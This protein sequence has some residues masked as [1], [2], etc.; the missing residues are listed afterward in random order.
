NGV[1]CI[2]GT[3]ERAVLR[4][5]HGGTG[6]ELWTLDKAFDG[7]IGFAGG[8][9]V[10]LG[11]VTRDGRLDIVALTGESHV[12][13]IQGDGTV[14]DV[15]DV[16]FAD[17]YPQ[18]TAWGGALAL[19][20]MDR[21]GW[22]EVAYSSAVWTTKD[23]TV[24]RLFKN[25]D[26]SFGGMSLSSSLSF[27]ADVTGDAD[28]E[29][30]VG[31]RVINKAGSTVWTSA[32]TGDGFAAVA[33]LDK[34][35]SPEV[36]VVADG[37][38]TVIQGSDGAQ[39]MPPYSL[40]GTGHGGSPTIAD[41]DGDTFPEIGIAQ[42]QVYLMLKPNL[43]TMELEGV[44]SAP[45]HDLSSS[46]TGSTVFDF[47]G[48]GSAEVV[49]NDEC[50]VWVY[51]GKT[52]AVKWATPTKSFT[53]TESSI[54]ADVDGD[55]HAEILVI[56]NGVRNEDPGGGGIEWDCTD[57]GY[58]IADPVTGRPAWEPDSMGRMWTGLRLFRD[59][60]NSWVNTR[61]LWNQHAYSVSNVCDPSDSA[62]APTG[63]Y[64]EI[65]TN[66]QKN[67]TLPWLNNFRQNVQDQGVFNAADALVSLSVTC[68][69]LPVLTVAV[70]NGG[71][72]ILPAGI[73]V[74]VFRVVDGKEELVAEAT[75][76]RVIYPGGS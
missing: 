8:V 46:V 56:G 38:V 60:A 61:A 15:S 52:G 34:N 22:S 57:D 54:V 16:P 51:D 14:E 66:A 7:S 23:K 53:A 20:D 63:L 67:W 37:K 32:A 62:C 26:G 17:P 18:G 28:P 35:G 76:E 6:E 29:L 33:D 11:D 36:V 43:T 40:G 1:F 44:W 13:I 74:S 25:E 39:W 3:C 4:A 47:E 55:G 50:Y 75:T 24:T 41:F 30:I 48:D 2:F 71:T 10:A 58:L 45:N 12:A 69:Q 21:D 9:S 49:Y 64:G 73:S 68:T 65:P 42:Q 5:I 59:I 72:A 70:R 19:G 27:F 31:N